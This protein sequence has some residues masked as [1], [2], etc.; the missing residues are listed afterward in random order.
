VPA[1]VI[2]EKAAQY[3]SRGKPAHR[4]QFL[5]D[6][7]YT[8]VNV[9]GAEYRGIVQYYLLAGNVCR[10]HRLRWAME[11]SLLKTLAAKHRSTVSKIAARY[12]AKVETPYGLRT[13]FEASVPRGAGRKPLVARF[14]G[15]SLTRQKAAVLA[16]RQV[17]N[18]RPR[19]E[20]ITRL[21]KGKC[22]LCGTSEDVRMHHIRKLADLDKG[23]PPTEWRQVME[24]KRRKT[25]VVCTG[26]H[27]T[28]HSGKPTSS[29]TK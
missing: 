14:G 9:Y 21:L 6:D 28:I 5:N 2:R 18:P 25:L 20:L 4:S 11:T 22:E 3:F 23:E 15:I 1:K 24:K 12:K 26:C 16:D 17:A 27:D 19:K 10:L 13:C 29:V 8:I 7:D